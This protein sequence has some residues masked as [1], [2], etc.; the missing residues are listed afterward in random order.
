MNDARHQLFGIQPPV[1]SAP[2]L[3][4][5]NLPNGIT[6]KIKRDATY[7]SPGVDMRQ[8]FDPTFPK[9]STTQCDNSADVLCNTANNVSTVAVNYL[10]AIAHNKYSFSFFF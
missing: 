3:L 10:T 8:S 2:Y 1:A 7:Q 9:I 6:E 4:F 5:Q